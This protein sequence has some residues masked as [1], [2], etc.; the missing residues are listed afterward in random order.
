MLLY[1]S[2]AITTVLQNT[3]VTHALDRKLVSLQTAGVEKRGVRGSLANTY[4]GKITTRNIM[5]R[6][7]RLKMKKLERFFRIL[8][9]RAITTQ[10]RMFDIIP[11]TRR[12]P[13]VMTR[14]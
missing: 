8:R 9:M 6:R 11:I 12:T 14:A 13:I 4:K 10:T 5:S 1:L 2:K 7:E 3:A